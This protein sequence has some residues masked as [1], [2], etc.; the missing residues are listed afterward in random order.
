MMVLFA[1][2]VVSA[3]VAYGINAN[4]YAAA[5]DSQVENDQLVPVL[6]A[7]TGSCGVERW[8]VKTGTDADA[9]L[10]N[11]ATIVPTTIATM[12]SYTPP[13]VLPDDNR[14]QP[15]ETTVYSID[16]TLTL[17]KL[18]TDSDY[19]LIIQDSV[20]R[21]MITEIPDPA[22][23]AGSAFLSGIQSA[24][25]EFD[26]AFTATTT[27]R[28]TSIP[29]RVRG[30]GFFDVLHGQT[31]V[32]PNG[33]ELHP[34]LDIQFNPGAAP[35]PVQPGAYHPLSPAR[36][37]DTRDGTGGVPASPLGPAGSLDVQVSG[38][39][40]GMVP[41]T[42]TAA[43][44][45]VTVTNTTAP[46]YL[47]VYPTGV[48]QPLASNLNW[49]AGQTVPNLVEVPLGIAGQVT[50]YNSAGRVDV[51]FDIAGY[52]STDAPSSVFGLYNPLVPARILDTRYGTGVPPGALGPGATI[53][54]PVNG[55][56]LVP[57][58]GV[59]AVILNVTVTGPT[60]P[61]YLTVYPTGTTPPLA[62][63]LNFIPGQTVANRV[64]VAVGMG[65]SLGQV[66]F[67]NRQGNVN[68]IADVGGWF[69]DSTDPSATGSKFMGVTPARILDTRDGTGTV[70]GVGGVGPVKITPFG[71]G[72]GLALQVAGTG[73]IPPMTDPSPPN[74]IVANVT[75][76]NTTAPSFL[77]AWPDGSSRPLASD[78]NW[79]AGRT[80]PNLVVVK[81]GS[82]GMADLYNAA[83]C[84]DV[85]V[86]VVGYYTGAL[87][88]SSSP[89]PP[90][91]SC[92]VNGNPWSY[93]FTCC[94]PITSP[95][96]NFCSYFS[97][98]ASFWNGVGYVEECV[99]STYSLS[100]GRSG[101]CSFHG[102]PLRQLYG[103]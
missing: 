98:I 68:V 86:D 95:P 36:I 11:T 90:M 5:S 63:N 13:S 97:C 34:V 75:V 1:V 7:S 10:V 76:T 9:G 28:S 14:I 31:G 65:S 47:T 80:V 18:E 39:G 84:T 41:T 62:S 67:F 70:S 16:A 35:P 54:L 51:I 85:I 32:A 101:V 4:G 30:I 59:S 29:V 74:A 66:S 6:A 100:G 83:G 45:N 24:R 82:S 81:L 2:V 52:V 94:N 27:F 78:V 92:P 103:P 89:L 99:D 19:H 96:A 12:Q 91:P 87:P 42:A 38:T 37:L 102:G 15:Q 43:V 69:T 40:G 58:T 93:N 20:G 26:S 25:S 8:P 17:Y 77:T 23:A 48:T 71:Q 22:C 60:A 73:G 46:S 49:L 57:S 56:G 61:S 33:I 50:I 55:A 64:M 44:L 21:T 53:N 79:I 72:E 88:P 3:P